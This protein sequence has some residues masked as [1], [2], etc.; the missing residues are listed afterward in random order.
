MLPFIYSR[1]L[2]TL[3]VMFGVT[4]IVFFLIH[5]VPG[6]PVEAMLGESSNPVDR[7]ALREA[8]GLNNSVTKQWLAYFGDTL[9]GE[10]GQSIYSKRA[11]FDIVAERLPA[12][13]ELAICGLLF[14]VIIGLPLGIVSAIRRGTY[15][16]RSAM[17]V[18]TLGVSI[19]N[20]VVGPVLI[21]FFSVYLG[22]LPVSGRGEMG[23]ALLPAL[24]LGSAMA[25]VLG[26]M[27]RSTLLEV[28]NED[29]IRTA[30]AKG[31]RSYRII[32]F[33]ALPNTLLPIITLL[34]LQFGALLAG[35]VITEV[36]FAWPGVGSLLMES[37][38]RRDYP[39]LQACV[40]LIS[41]TYVLVNM[42]TE[43][44]YAYIDPRLRLRT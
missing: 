13:L 23:A 10:L 21:L 6:D 29:Y 43:L 26:R 24:T 7:N 22:W 28:L 31:L 17:L 18:S 20:F 38:Q 2:S 9:S 1:L 14:A 37:I 27:V 33:H 3:I 42:M 15:I 12:T 44:A 40:L 39:V 5:A 4:T 19:P 8:L 11:V 41:L 35:T 16:D 32:L 36:V 30:K 34:G 25:G